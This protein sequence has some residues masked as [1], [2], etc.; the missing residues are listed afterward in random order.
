[1][2][3]VAQVHA[4]ARKAFDSG[5]TKSLTFRKEQI[6]QLGYLIKDNADRLREALRADLGRPYEETDMCAP[7]STHTIWY[8]SGLTNPTLARIHRL[9]FGPAFGQIKLAYEIVEKWN[10][11][12]SVDFSLN[13]FPMRPKMFPEPKGVALLIAPFNIPIFL[14]FGPLVRCRSFLLNLHHGGWAH[15][16]A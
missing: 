12:Q 7:K 1:M 8:S 16:S 6:A 14:L 11:P 10:K 15:A 3:T 2:L 13:W 5:K 9:D 4:T